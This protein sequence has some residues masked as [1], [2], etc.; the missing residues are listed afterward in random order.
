ML[1]ASLMLGLTLLGFAAWLE[2]RE[3]QGFDQ[4]PLFD[5]DYLRRRRRGRQAVHILL[6]AAG[7]L[8]LAAAV[9]GRGILWAALW[10]AVCG[11]LILVLLIAIVDVWRTHRYFYRKLPEL[12]QQ[13]LRPDGSA[14]DESPEPDS[15]P[16]T[17]S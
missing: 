17:S 4:G 2:W 8:I 10:S 3:R 6:A 13:M 12:R 14:E 7:V 11:L 16:E 9:A 1:P 5:A 15:A